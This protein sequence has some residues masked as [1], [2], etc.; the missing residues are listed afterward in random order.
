MRKNVLLDIDETL[1]GSQSRALKDRAADHVIAYA[2]NDKMYVY[3]RPHLDWF[4]D[5]VFE[6]FD[7]S[8]FTA[9]GQEYCLEIIENIIAPPPAPGK[10]PRKL[11]YIFFS[12]HC[13]YSAKHYDG[14]DKSL[15]MLHKEFG[16]ASMAIDNTVL[17]DD[18][19]DLKKSQ[20][21]ANVVTIPKYF[22]AAGEKDTDTALLDIA[23]RLFKD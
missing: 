4:L 15:D 7:V 23:T 11:E 10:R 13:E 21:H 2:D 3:K 17:V 1:I 5:H 19:A 22:A 6:H 8:I 12:K 16:L 20:P 9:S 18:R 14:L